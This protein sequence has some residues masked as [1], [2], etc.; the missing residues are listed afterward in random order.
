MDTE[1]V[2]GFVT[3]AFEP[4]ETRAE[5]TDQRAKDDAE[6]PS[7]RRVRRGPCRERIRDPIGKVHRLRG[8]TR[9]SPK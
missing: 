1:L 9:R 3:D 4:A 7:L 2:M 8:E 5:D 6:K